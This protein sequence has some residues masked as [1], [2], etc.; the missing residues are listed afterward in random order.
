MVEK[1]C[2]RGSLKPQSWFYLFTSPTTHLPGQSRRKVRASNNPKQSKGQ[3]FASFGAKIWGSDCPPAPQFLQ[4]CCSSTFRVNFLLPRIDQIVNIT[5]LYLYAFIY[6]HKF[7]AKLFKVHYM[8]F[9]VHGNLPLGPEFFS[10]I[11]NFQK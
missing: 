1:L 4:P 7:L 5:D 2:C 10:E 11:L 6:V 3:D 8:N 9:F